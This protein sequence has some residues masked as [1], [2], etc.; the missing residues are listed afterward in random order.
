MEKIH[1]TQI[2]MDGSKSSFIDFLTSDWLYKIIP[3]FFVGLSAKIAND[4]RRGRHMSM[5][6]WISIVFMSL[7]ATFFS[8]WICISYG[9][10][11]EHTVIVNAFATLFS[12]QI[13]RIL[14]SNFYPVVSAWIKQNLK[15][16]LTAI[17]NAEEN[18]SKEDKDGEF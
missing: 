16:T 4:V 3:S 1:N 6:G 10:T 9:V 7:S 8:N 2:R 11:K 14:F 13:F 5:I 12:E 17:D 18:K 15:Y